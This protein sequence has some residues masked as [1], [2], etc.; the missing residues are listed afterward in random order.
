MSKEKFLQELSVNLSSLPESEIKKH[1]DDYEERFDQLVEGGVEETEAVEEVANEIFLKLPVRTLIKNRIRPKDGWTGRNILIA[2]LT[3][4]VWIP[5][6]L[7]MIAVT[8]AVLLAIVFVLAVFIGIVITML[9]F[10]IFAIV[11]GFGFIPL[12]RGYAIL[13]VGM[14]FFSLGTACLFT[15]VTEF[16]ITGLRRNGRRLYEK[17]RMSLLRKEA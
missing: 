1:L 14:G 12:G 2:V 5:L 8:A 13:T 17:I 6:A 10:G 15:L 16:L 7:A 9:I 4:P 3:A 11:R